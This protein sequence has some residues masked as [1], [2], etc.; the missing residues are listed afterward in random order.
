M[1]GDSPKG[2]RLQPQEGSCCPSAPRSG[3]GPPMPGHWRYTPFLAYSY[4]GD[5]QTHPADPKSKGL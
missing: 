5:P 4:L 1:P 2:E 3:Q